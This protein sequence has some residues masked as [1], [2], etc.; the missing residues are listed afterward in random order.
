GPARFSAK[1]DAG[2]KEP[3]SA[4]SKVHAMPTR[5]VRAGDLVAVDVRSD[6]DLTDAAAR[7]ESAAF[8]ELYRRHADAAWRVAMAVTRNPHDAA[9]AVSDAFARVFQAL[10]QGRLAGG[11]PFRPYLLTSTRNA[12]VDVLRR[13]GRLRPVDTVEDVG[14]ARATPGPAEHAV[15]DEDAKLV[16]RA[17]S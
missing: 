14:A 3:R 11:V 2:D 1:G 15:A 7:G 4:M 13:A 17:F 10:P 8:E 9:D 6:A 16:A 12:A 5:S